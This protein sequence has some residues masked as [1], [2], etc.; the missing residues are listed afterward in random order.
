MF[1]VLQEQEENNLQRQTVRFL[2]PPRSMLVHL[3]SALH[4]FPVANAVSTSVEGL[5]KDDSL[6]RVLLHHRNRQEMGTCC[7][8]I[9]CKSFNPTAFQCQHTTSLHLLV[10]LAREDGEAEVGWMHSKGTR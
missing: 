4:L 6:A 10:A 8:Q 2:G 3:P 9:P 5:S 7:L 1:L